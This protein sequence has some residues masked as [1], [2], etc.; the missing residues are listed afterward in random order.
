MVKY[1]C[2][3]TEYSIMDLGYHPIDPVRTITVLDDIGDIN[4]LHRAIN[5]FQEV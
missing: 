1:K 2:D 3:I 4:R 5:E